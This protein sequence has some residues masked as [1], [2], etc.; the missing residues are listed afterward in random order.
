M[1]GRPRWR[2]FR[3]SER[4]F[5]SG[6]R[7]KAPA[8]TREKSG[9]ERHHLSGRGLLVDKV[10]KV[11]VEVAAENPLLVVAEPN[12]D[13]AAVGVHCQCASKV[14]RVKFAH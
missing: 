12:V 3:R 1:T 6:T 8:G 11:S 10:G 2:G 7:Q 9:N 4:F 14:G 13:N 5:A